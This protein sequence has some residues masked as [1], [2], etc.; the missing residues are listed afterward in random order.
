MPTH[1]LRVTEEVVIWAVILHNNS[2]LGANSEL[3]PRHPG[4]SAIP[5]VYAVLLTPL[6]VFT[7]PSVHEDRQRWEPRGIRVRGWGWS[8]RTAR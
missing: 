2:K 8:E 6:A 3:S 4:R 5:S 7:M 1:L